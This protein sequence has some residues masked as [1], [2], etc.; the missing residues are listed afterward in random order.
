MRQIFGE[1]ANVALENM[2]LDSVN[3]SG[4]ENTVGFSDCRIGI[5][6]NG[7]DNEPEDLEGK[8]DD[9]ECRIKDI[10]CAALDTKAILDEVQAHFELSTEIESLK[11]ESEE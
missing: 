10:K 4:D 7:S 9:L 3:I 6:A 1:G 8:A 11:A 5:R 2:P